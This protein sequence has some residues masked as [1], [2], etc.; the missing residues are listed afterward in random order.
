MASLNDSE[1]FK[2]LNKS[3]NITTKI[4]ALVTKGAVLDRSYIEEQYLQ[5]QRTRISPIA[6]RVLKAFD[7]G[8]I[9]LIWN[10][11]DH[12]TI[13]VPFVC[14]SIAGKLTACIFISD[15]SSLTKDEAAINI[16]M[17]KLYTLMESAYVA[18]KYYTNPAIFTRNGAFLKTNASIYASMA[19]R[20][21]NRDYALS[22]DKDAYD[23]VFYGAARFFLER[24]IGLTN[25][26]LSHAYAMACLKNP[27][28]QAISLAED[29]YTV[30]NPEAVS[31][32]VEFYKKSNKKM[33]ELG[34]RYYFERW[35]S[36]FGTGACLSIDAYPY[37]YYVIANVL[38]SGFLINVPSVSE[39]VK[40]A[41]GINKFY[42][43]IMRIV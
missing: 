6:D 35:I 14:L 3:S 41:Q 16:E 5:I 15:F 38:I 4:K 19:L 13:A 26:E 29:L 2:S 42:A 28:Q 18:L 8:L 33:E 34:Y 40:N 17:K 10:K 1:T 31:K 7:D 37:F 22:L 9:K 21:L 27:N 25:R 20:I 32:L 12:L 30:V 23:S 36:S 24:V 11:N 39:I 43:E